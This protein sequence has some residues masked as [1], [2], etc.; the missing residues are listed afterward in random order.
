MTDALFTHVSTS[1]EEFRPSL[2][3]LHPS[4]VQQAIATADPNR[5]LQLSPSPISEQKRS[6]PRSTHTLLSK[7][8]SGHSSALNSY[9]ARI[10]TMQDH[11]CPASGT[12]DKTTSHL[13]SCLT[14]PTHLTPLDLSLDLVSTA[15]FLPGVPSS[16]PISILLSSRSSLLYT[17]LRK[18]IYE[19]RLQQ[20]ERISLKQ[21]GQRLHLI[22]TYEYVNGLND[23]TPEGLFGRDGNVQTR[24]NGQKLILR[25]FKTSQ[26]TN[27]FR[28]KIAA[29]WY[30]LPENTISAG[31]VNTFKTHI[32]KILDFKPPII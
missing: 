24:N 18:L 32:E 2:N 22:E 9:L 19:R 25:N 17:Q 16:H 12:A 23:V 14:T 27:F 15:T 31:N 20:L 8:R 26:A 4:A 30:Q 21:R 6:L 7:L 5:V 28:V 10:G 29:T 11:T 13:F 3:F 1:Q